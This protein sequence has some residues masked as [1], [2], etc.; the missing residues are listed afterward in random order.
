[1]EEVYENRILPGYLANP[2]RKGFK[3]FPDL[4]N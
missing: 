1:M 3:N 4:Y 2:I